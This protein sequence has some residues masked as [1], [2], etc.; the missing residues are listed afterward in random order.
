[1]LNYN[2]YDEVDKLEKFVFHSLSVC[3]V[4]GVYSDTQGNKYSIQEM[5]REDAEIID[6]LG[7]KGGIINY[8]GTLKK[9]GVYSVFSELESYET[10]ASF[11]KKNNYN[12]ALVGE[13]FCS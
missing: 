1:M 11:I 7:K 3:G 9:K 4:D 2:D 6:A 13:K 8:K 10:L 12:K 5:S